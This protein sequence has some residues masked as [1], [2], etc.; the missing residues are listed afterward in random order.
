MAQSLRARLGPLMSK[1]EGTVKPAYNATEKV[2]VEQYDKILKGG[3]QYVV[4]DPAEADKLLKKWFYTNLSRIPA[5]IKQVDH[6]WGSVKSKLAQRHDLPLTEVGMYALFVAEVYAW[7][8]VG[9]IAGRG[10]TVSGY[11]I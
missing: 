9:E 4:K 11:K 1:L 8:V 10:F 6:E 7:F 5:G 3:E 2:V